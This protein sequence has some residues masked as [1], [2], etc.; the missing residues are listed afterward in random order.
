MTLHYSKPILTVSIN[1]L[2]IHLIILQPR[3]NNNLKNLG[4]IEINKNQIFDL[5][6]CNS[7]RGEQILKYHQLHIVGSFN[8]LLN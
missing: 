8:F 1:K 3:T 4:F 6:K 2:L 5:C 7:D